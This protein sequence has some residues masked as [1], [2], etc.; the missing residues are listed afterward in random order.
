MTPADFTREFLR[1]YP[2]FFYLSDDELR[3]VVRVAGECFVR[4]QD[5]VTDLERDL[6][7]VRQG[8]LAEL[9]GADERLVEV[10]DEGSVCDLAPAGGGLRTVAREDAIVLRIPRTVID[11]L[12]ATNERFADFFQRRERHRRRFLESLRSDLA[13][14]AAGQGGVERVMLG[15]R[16]RELAQRDLVWCAP[17]TTVQ[18]AA[19]LMRERGVSSIFV[20]EERHDWRRAGILTTDD[21]RSRVVAEGLDPTTPVGGLASRPLRT[22]EGG[23]LAFEALLE[24]MQAG[25]NYLGVIEE[26]R[27][28]ALISS[29]DLMLLQGNAPLLLARAIARQED[30][31]GL[32]RLV[33]RAAAAVPRLVQEGLSPVAIG[34]LMAGLTDRVT[35]RLLTLA[36]AA[37][38]PAPLPWCW[39]AM[40]SEGRREQTFLT[41]QDNALVHADPPDEA[42]AQA[43]AAY[44]PKFAAWVGERLVECGYPPC[45]AGY[46]AREARWCRPL[47]EWL[48]AVDE[49]VDSPSPDEVMH[50]LVFLDL[51]PVGGDFA[52]G[53]HLAAELRARARARP[54]FLRALAAAGVRHTP[55]LGFFRAFAV[56][57]RGPHEGELDLKLRGT[58]PILD[59]VRLR[60]L[61]A[62]V[63]E[64]NTFDRLAALARLGRLP[65]AEVDELQDTLEF[66]LLLRLRNQ[67][68]QR[69]AGE[70]LTNRIAPERLSSVERATLREAF[71]VV[72]RHQD[73]LRLDYQLRG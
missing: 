55:P 62:D 24:M 50:A 41:D 22:I 36:T 7:V 26:D 5:E 9:A 10:R 4:A 23:R 21:L 33:E 29:R 66:L 6:L 43:A 46:M 48:R 38:G 28:D 63:V 19:R 71:R 51:R 17:P 11:E 49:W 69:Q 13:A 3:R 16:V 44:F 45:P 27:L 42:A 67:V 73:A 31:A 47:G 20:L 2:P 54:K 15:T 70:P 56:A 57:S 40:G 8:L 34:Q 18:E 52:L 72:D 25:V 64:T 58:M 60:A 1:R 30:A 59:L 14:Q 32:R 65:V 68:A 53:E 35:G 61:E 37:L 12:I 39:L